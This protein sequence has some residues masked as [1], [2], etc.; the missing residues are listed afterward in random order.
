MVYAGGGEDMDIRLATLS[1]EQHQMINDLEEKLNMVLIA[2]EGY[3]R[4]DEQGN[5]RQ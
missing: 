5:P 3:Q 2:Y 4:E 1:Q